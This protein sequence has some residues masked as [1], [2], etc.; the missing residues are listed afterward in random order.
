MSEDDARAALAQSWSGERFS[1]ERPGQGWR[2]ECWVARS[3]ERSLFVAFDVPVAPLRRLAELG[4]TPRITAHGQIVGRSWLAQEWIDGHSPDRAW[5]G[6]HVDQ[7]GTLYGLVHGDAV[8]REIVA[9]NGFGG[10]RATA[11][12][13]AAQLRARLA[14]RSEPWLNTEEVVSSTALFL[15]RAAQLV[16]G[17]LVPTHDEPNTSNMLVRDDRL[18]LLDWDDIVLA[19]AC[20]DAGPLLWWYLPEQQWGEVLAAM[21]IEFDEQCRT[22]L[23]WYAAR[24]SL[25]VALWLAEQGIAEKETVQQE[26]GEPAGDPDHGFLADFRAAVRGEPN[27]RG[28]N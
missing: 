28:G 19:D 22:K 5:L 12:S 1:I 17:P 23:Y 6:H 20:L 10:R 24:I 21:G 3:A 4:V 15:D 13:E 9:D 26:V 7:L 2:K 11:A 27:P 16:D 14:R 25:S 18:W 8:L